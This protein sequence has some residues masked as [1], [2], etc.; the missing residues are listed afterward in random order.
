[1][2][3]HRIL[4]KAF[5]PGVPLQTLTLFPRLS[6]SQAPSSLLMG[7]SASASSLLS[8]LIFLSLLSTMHAPLLH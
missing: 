6:L 3:F 1:M 5:L 7:P 4:A 2:V 8:V